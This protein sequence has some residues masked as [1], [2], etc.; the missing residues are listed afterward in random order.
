MA[1][2]IEKQIYITFQIS[3]IQVGG[4]KN[5]RINLLKYL[6]LRDLFVFNPISFYVNKFLTNQIYLLYINFYTIYLSEIRGIL[7]TMLLTI[8]IFKLEIL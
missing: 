3:E 7:A 8:F 1:N 6:N 2:W 4:F 5:I